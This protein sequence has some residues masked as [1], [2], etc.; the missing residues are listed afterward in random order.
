MA[1][2][3]GVEEGALVQG[4]EVLR[5]RAEPFSSSTQRCLQFSAQLLLAT[6]GR[7]IG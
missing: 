7:L 6:V 4:Q 3:R 2:N 1:V 5:A